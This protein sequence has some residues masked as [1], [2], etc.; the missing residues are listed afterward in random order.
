MLLICSIASAYE[1]VAKVSADKPKEWTFTIEVSANEKDFTAFQFDVEVK[2][3]GEILPSQVRKG[4]VLN[5]HSVSVGGSAGKYRI[6]SYSIDNSQFLKREGAIVI[7]TV[8]GDVEAITISNI[9]FVDSDKLAEMPAPN[10]ELPV[11]ADD[12]A[13]HSVQ[14]SG[15]RPEVIYNLK[16]Q[17]VYH[18]DR[19]GIYIKNGK[20]VKK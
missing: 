20:K 11:S 1:I 10:V 7:F 3:D 5:N 19:R 13:I 6:L 18:I 12:D 16:G 9:L 8:C 14:Q 17:R 15:I 4:E 2:G